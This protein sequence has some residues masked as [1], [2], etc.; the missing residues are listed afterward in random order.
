MIDDKI[1]DR[2]ITDSKITDNKIDDGRNYLLD[3]CKGV[4]AKGGNYEQN[5][6]YSWILCGP[7]C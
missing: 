1:T 7:G 4:A 2:K 5:R 3:F 6:S